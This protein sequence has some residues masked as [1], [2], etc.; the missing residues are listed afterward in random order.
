[1]KIDYVK[2]GT[3]FI[4]FFGL[5]YFYKKLKLDEDTNTTE[6]YYKMVNKYL[7]NKNSLGI[8]S[9]PFLWIHLH[10]D[11][12]IIPE[13]NSRNWIS[14][15]SRNTKEF[16]QPYQYLTIKSII[17]KCS[18]DFSICLIDDES[19][20][21]IIPN[22]SVD[23]NTIA[24]PIKTHIRQLALA[25]ILNVYGGMFVPSSFICLKSLRPLY[26]ANMDE[27]KMFVG[28]FLNNTSSISNNFIPSNKLM[29]CNAN[30]AK[31]KEYINY[32]EILNSTDFGAQS[33]FLGKPNE[34]LNNAVRNDDINNIDGLYIGTKKACG[35]PTLVDELVGST[36][37][38]F[39]EKAVGI[40]IPWDE[41]IQRTT[42]QWFSRMSPQQVLESN[43]VI[44]RRLLEYL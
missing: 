42:L 37:I 5:S 28:E 33:D 20:K 13:V 38:D 11:N 7:L 39:H 10:N 34:W 24:N 43:T 36:H 27:D 12:T 35:K 18:D 25:N 31:M 6:Y 22:W 2:Y 32:L 1:M 44:G 41:L 21:K 3:F 17:D 26:D 8:N 30:N 14:F 40:Y 23:L 4:V 15:K 29:G 16:N 19:F 9:K